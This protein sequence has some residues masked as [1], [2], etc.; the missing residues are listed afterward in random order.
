MLLI[1]CCK[2]VT[3]SLKSTSV[4]PHFGGVT[5]CFQNFFVTV[6]FSLRPS[7]SMFHD[8]MSAV[9]SLKLTKPPFFAQLVLFNSVFLMIVVVLLP[10]VSVKLFS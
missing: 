10:V 6:A 9:I 4:L 7:F 2:L 1:A 8:L 5:V 3:Y